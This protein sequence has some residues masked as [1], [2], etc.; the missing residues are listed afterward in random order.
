[1]N[2]ASNVVDRALGKKED[3]PL[4][5]EPETDP[6]TLMRAVVFRGK[7][8]VAVEWVPKPLI[9]QSKDAIIRITAFTICPGSDGHLYAGEIPS[10]REGTIMGHEAIGI[11]ENVGEDVTKFKEGDRVAI[12]F[13]VSCGECSFCKRGEF[14]GCSQTNDSKLM[15]KVYS[16]CHGGIFGYGEMLGGIPG[17]QAEYV[18]VPYADV[19]LYHIPENVPDERALYI[20]DIV[21]TAYHA[22]EQCNFKKGDSVYISGLGPIGACTARWA[23]ILGASKIVASEPVRERAALVE[24]ALGIIVINPEDVDNI[25]DA[26]LEILPGGADCCVEAAG[27]RFARSL[28]HKVQRKLSMETD[29]PELVNDCFKICRKYGSISL[30]A[31]YAGYANS[32]FLGAI[33]LKHLNISGGQTPCQRIFP[34]VM[35]YLES[36][37]FD[38]T[39]LLTNT[40]RMDEVPKA[41]ENLFYKRDGWIKVICKPWDDPVRQIKYRSSGQ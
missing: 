25:V 34:K 5:S 12:C 3:I 40:I 18:R 22:L 1:M 35:P 4:E 11:I 39:F 36:G 41:Y 31:D 13:N 6:H 32:F 19:N 17:S 20:T 15:E 14:S 7:E 37:E 2:K 33:Q 29:T 28:V 10:V 27:F 26:V 38:P 21:S 16:H 8:K 30:I 9:T 23:Q 24:K